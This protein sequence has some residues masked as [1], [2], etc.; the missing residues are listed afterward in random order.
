MNRHTLALQPVPFSFSSVGPVRDNMNLVE[1]H[2]SASLSCSDFF[3]SDPETLPKPRQSPLRTVCRCIDGTGSPH[4][5]DFQ[6][7]C[8]FADLTRPREKLNG[9]WCRFS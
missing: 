5:R 6:Q 8:C 7:Q 3:G 4:V 1:Q 9:R 2:D